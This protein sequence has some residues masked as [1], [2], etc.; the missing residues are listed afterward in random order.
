MTT[1]ANSIQVIDSWNLTSIGIIAELKHQLNGLTTGSIIKSQSTNKEW[2]VRKRILYNHTFDKQK[3]F[4]NERTTYSH[5]S[6]DNAEKLTISA[7][8]IIDKEEQNIFQYQLQPIGQNS[9]LT[10]G[11][12]FELVEIVKYACP[13]CGYKTFEHEPNG[14]FEICEVCFWEDDPIQLEDPNYEGGANPMSL[15]QAQRNFIEFGACDREMLQNVR[16]PGLNE[17]RDKDWKF[18]DKE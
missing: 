18:L 17:Q 7:Q 10:K 15:R 6:F 4:L 1:S 14:S 5:L 3:K 9:T 11:D 12:I 2:R 8:N 16:Q 13:C